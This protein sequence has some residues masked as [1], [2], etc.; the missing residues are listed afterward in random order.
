MLA[1]TSLATMTP[2]ER[3]WSETVSWQV[4]R[5]IP[6]THV[7]GS[8]RTE[9]AW[10]RARCFADG[11]VQAS[12]SRT[13]TAGLFWTI[14]EGVL[15][16]GPHLP[17]VAGVG[18]RP[19]TRWLEGLITGQADPQGT[20]YIGVSRVLP[21]QTVTWT[22]GQPVLGNWSGPQTW[23]D[24]WLRGE[25]AR[26]AY[27]DAFD[28]ALDDLL[29]ADEP[30]C[31]AT[32]GG[33]D[34]TFVAAWLARRG[35]EVNALVHVPHP[36]ADLS[37]EG[38]W[39][40]DEADLVRT[41]AAS[42]PGRI[43][44]IEVVN[45]RLTQPLDAA[46][47]LS[48]RTWTPAGHAGNEV[49]IAHISE[50]ARELGARRIFWGSQGNY[51]FS[52]DH[53]YAWRDYF[54]RGRLLGLAELTRYGHDTGLSWRGS[55]ARGVLPLLR[56]HAGSTLPWLPAVSMPDMS[57]REGFLRALTMGSPP[58]VRS[59]PLSEAVMWVD[60]FAASSVLHVAAAIEPSEWWRGA[61]TRSFARTLGA[62]VVP[63]A[64]RSRRRRGAQGWDTWFVI[65]NQRQRYLDE[66]EALATTAVIAD[67]VDVGAVRDTVLSWPWG[68]VQGPDPVAVAH[69]TSLLA[70]GTFV[71]KAS[72]R[73][74]DKGATASP[75]T[76]RSPRG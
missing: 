47:A 62:G 41:L 8:G 1:A 14:R 20:P 25:S 5:T 43:R 2:D 49:W 63:D 60:P 13:L 34:S 22:G 68:E 32:S 53:T 36:G 52:G 76:P 70:F 39:D 57:S 61:R 75:S 54:R 7:W 59:Q 24:P 33:L 16:M 51:S 28:A 11:R 67:H 50:R 71:R 26:G 66:V 12:V 17:E 4:G 3:V 38:G 72:S 30:V 44:V 69:L 64:I 27:L 9:D 37:P 19:D 6:T 40:P 58:E 56:D 10:A 73:A 23:S 45:E 74:N 21:G 18:A 31:V 29:V 15:V 35:V 46:A 65:R 42:Y 48:E 55:V